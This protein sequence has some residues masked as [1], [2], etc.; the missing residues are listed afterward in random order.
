MEAD[1]WIAS[2]KT[3]RALKVGSSTYNDLLRSPEYGDMVK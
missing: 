3:G 2:P 1:G